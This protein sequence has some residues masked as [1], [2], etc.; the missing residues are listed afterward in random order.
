[1][2]RHLILKK[3]KKI[4]IWITHTTHPTQSGNGWVYPTRSNIKVDGYFAQPNLV[5][6]IWFG[7]RFCLNPTQSGPCTP[8]FEIA[9][10]LA[11]F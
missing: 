9:S 4:K 2:I 1:M 5:Y 10:K 7:F 8:L 6:L 3:I 11:I